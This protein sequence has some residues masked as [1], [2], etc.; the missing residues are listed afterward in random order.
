MSAAKCEIDY[1]QGRQ[2]MDTC[3]LVSRVVLVSNKHWHLGVAAN[4]QA[5]MA[6][7]NSKNSLHTCHDGRASQ[8][9]PLSKSAVSTEARDTHDS[10]PNQPRHER[11]SCC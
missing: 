8:N 3:S 11:R 6:C 10:L 7:K 9:R 5:A 2:I 1:L 4:W